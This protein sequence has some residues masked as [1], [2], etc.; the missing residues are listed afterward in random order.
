V[1]N[2]KQP[3]LDVDPNTLPNC[4]CVCGSI[5]FKQ[6]TK[7]KR[8]FNPNGE[9]QYFSLSINICNNCDTELPKHPLIMVEG[10]GNL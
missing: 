1:N 10:G 2:K 6:L 4:M 3:Y 5:L 9:A 7:V 8:I